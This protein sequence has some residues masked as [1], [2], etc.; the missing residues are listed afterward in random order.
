MR[1]S[2]FPIL[3]GKA[4]KLKKIF[5]YTFIVI[6]QSLAVKAVTFNLRLKPKKIQFSLENLIFTL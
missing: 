3:P 4:I 5:K 2:S 6:K 1:F